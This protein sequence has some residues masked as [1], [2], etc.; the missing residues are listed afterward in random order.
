MRL[1]RCRVV[2]ALTSLKP[3]KMTVSVS[4]YMVEGQK[5]AGKLS[6]SAVLN[7]P[8]IPTLQATLNSN[9]DKDA[10]MARPFWA[11]ELLVHLRPSSVVGT[12]VASLAAYT[13]LHTPL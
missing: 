7:A 5:M 6:K 9:A 12:T 10:V 2:A 3:A 1:M 13:D 11:L 8:G 4:G